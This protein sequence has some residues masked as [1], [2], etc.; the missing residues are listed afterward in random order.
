MPTPDALPHTDTLPNTQATL[1]PDHHWPVFCTP[2]QRVWPQYT[3]PQYTRP[4]HTG[5]Q[6][7]PQST[8]HF[9]LT[10]FSVSDFVVDEFAKQQI[11]LPSGIDQAVP[12]RQAEY[13]A[14]R[15]CAREALQALTGHL[16]VPSRNE[17]RSPQWPQG[18]TGAITHS[19]GIAAALVAPTLTYAGIGLD[20]EQLITDDKAQRLAEHILTPEEMTHWHQEWQAQPG[21]WLTRIFSLKEA[22]F[23][24]LYPITGTRFYFQD[25]KLSEWDST[26]GDVQLTLLTDLS[27]QWHR[28]QTV[29]GQAI[30]PERWPDY[31]FSRVLIKSYQ[32]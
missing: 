5:P 32:D 18:I 21:P 16:I 8:L 19:H 3:R 26:T 12:K 14:G 10:H 24:A 11:P 23:K 20:I 6:A 9:A 1:S 25:A 30:T 7:S 31:L 15:L 13:L 22:L 17:D 2:P 4:Q 28:G 27:P 29:T